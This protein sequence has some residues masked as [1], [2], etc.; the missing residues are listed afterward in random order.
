MHPTLLPG[1]TQIPPQLRRLLPRT[2]LLAALERDIPA[3]KLTLISAPAGYGKSALLS[4]WAHTSRYP[5]AWLSLGEDDNDPDRLFRYLLAAWQ[6]IQ[7]GAADSPFGLLLSSLSPPADAVLSAFLSL[8]S[9]LPDHTVLAF[10]DIHLISEPAIYQALTVLLDHLP[11]NLHLILAGRGEPP[12]PLARYRA[13]HE[14]QEIRAEDLTLTLDETAEFLTQLMALD[15]APAEIALLHTQLEGWVAGLHLV[16]LT[17]RHPNATAERLVVSGRHRFIA[18]YLHDDVLA[19]VPAP[20]HRFLLQTCLLDRLSAGLCAAVTGDDD[21]QATLELLERDNLFL[22]PL[23]DRREWFRYHRLFAGVLQEE[24]HRRHPDDIAPIHP[25]P[26]FGTWTTTSRT[27][28]STTRSPQTT[29][30]SSPRS[31]TATSQ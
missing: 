7:P 27:Q 29:R 5:V 31:S 22:L 21:C 23:D 30:P 24:L 9:D 14:L 15:L 13:R 18:D 4:Q 19:H 20:V 8:A 26:R 1:K 6:T 17:L 3:A 2:Q 28:P 10:D 11:P 12:V 16:S 25:R